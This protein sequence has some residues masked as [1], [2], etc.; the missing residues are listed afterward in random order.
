[1]DTFFW[2]WEFS[3]L[4]DLDGDSRAVAG[5][6]GD[7][8]DLLDDVVTLQDFAEDDVLAIEMAVQS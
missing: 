6:L 4:C 3:A 5:L 2:Y 7:V 1:V 8:F